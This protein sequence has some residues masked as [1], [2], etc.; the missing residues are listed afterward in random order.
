MPAER[1]NSGSLLIKQVSFHKNELKRLEIAKQITTAAIDN[2]IANLKY[3][4]ARGAEV[5]EQTEEMDEIK[6]YAGK[7][8]DTEELMGYEGAAKKIYSPPGG[9]Y[10]NSLSI[11]TQGLKT[12]PIILSMLSFLM[13]IW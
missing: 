7:A 1:N 5:K 12:R 2:S 3:H 4:L 11:L 13:E 10:L 6:S 9:I 8:T